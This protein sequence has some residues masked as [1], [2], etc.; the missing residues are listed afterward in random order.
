VNEFGN[1]GIDNDLIV[2]ANRRELR[3]CG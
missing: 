3:F 2:G 1:I